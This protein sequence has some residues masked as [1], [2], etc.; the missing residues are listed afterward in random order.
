MET[1]GILLPEACRMFL[2]GR[3]ACREMLGELSARL[4]REET[5]AMLSVPSYKVQ[6]WLDPQRETAFWASERKLIWLV[7][8]LV[9]APYR[10]HTAFDVMTFGR[11][12]PESQK[13]KEDK[14][15]Y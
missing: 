11:F 10:L 4:G 1:R 15:K 8:S 2:P 5:A 7:H 13:P 9:F 14:P 6:G 3:E 12:L